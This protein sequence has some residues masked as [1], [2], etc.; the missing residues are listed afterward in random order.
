[1]TLDLATIVHD[2]A[3]GLMAADRKQPRANNLRSKKPF[4]QGIGPHTEAQTVELVMRELENAPTDKY[5]HWSTGVPYPDFPRNKCDLCLGKAP[6]WDWSIEIKM[7]RF[8]GDNGKLNDNI[9]MHLLSP[10]PAHRSAVWDCEKLSR[11]RLIGRKATLIYGFDHEQWP[12]DPGIEAFEIIARKKVE[13]GPRVSTNFSGLIH[14][15][16]NQGR[17]F[18][19]ELTGVVESI[20]SNQNIR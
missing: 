1:M 2:F 9:L 5:K 13:L 16:H 14:P 18:A 7:V 10:Y 17:V 8:L 12:L 6:H 4:Q 3:D 20:L 15:I 11:S 19:W